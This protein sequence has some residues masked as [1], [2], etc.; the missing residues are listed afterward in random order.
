VSENNL[1]DK[2][3]AYFALRLTLGVNIFLHGAIRVFWTGTNQFVENT[4][5]Q[6]AESPL[7]EFSVRAFAYTIPFS[8]I[9]LGLLLILG[10]WTRWALFFGGLLMTA[11]VFGTATRS[12]WNAL[13]TQMIY[14][15]I[16]YLL[17]IHRH[18]DFYSLDRLIF[19]KN[20]RTASD[21]E[22]RREF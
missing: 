9:L 2:H 21:S 8:E 3:L 4:V 20:E 1:F 19:K 12:D 13:G 15:A 18:F 11:L 17:L 16:Y 6:F 7:P 22:S 5:K 10:L 14:A